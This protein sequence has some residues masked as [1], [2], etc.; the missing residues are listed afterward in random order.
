MKKKE[1][2]DFFFF[3]GKE[4]EGMKAGWKNKSAAEKTRVKIPPL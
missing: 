4:I 1:R 3:C 2:I